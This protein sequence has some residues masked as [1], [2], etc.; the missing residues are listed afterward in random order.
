MNRFYET[1]KILQWITALGMI[2]FM[3]V[4]F[5]LWMQS[6]RNNLFAF[7]LIFLAAPLWQFLATPFFTLIG[8][9]TYV[10]P[11][12]LVY[13]ASQKKYDLH[14]GTSFDYLFL[15]HRYKPGI[16]LRQKNLEFYIA[17]L[18]NI[19]EKIENK[20]LSEEVIIRG[21]S[22]FFNNRTAGRLGF[23]LSKTNSAEKIN[24]ALNYLD[25]IWMYSLAHGKL[26]FPNLKN[27]KTA[28]IRGKDL[29]AGKSKLQ[30][31]HAFFL[32]KQG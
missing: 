10:S 9:Y 23:K 31:L 25:L 20:S 7:F 29:S 22:Y 21:S 24:M 15:M 13:G 6:T 5:I 12:L 19:I 1:H 27:I 8:L 17:G 11:M 2:I 14:N 32:K 4:L 18:L 26:V 30:A 28:E 16:Q 3:L